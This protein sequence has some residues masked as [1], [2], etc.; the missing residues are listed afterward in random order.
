LLERRT[1]ERESRRKLLFQRRENENK[2]NDF[3]ASCKLLVLRPLGV[4]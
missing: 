2:L 1:K 3:S 4:A